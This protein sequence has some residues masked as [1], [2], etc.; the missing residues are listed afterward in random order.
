MT[1]F[2]AR[3]TLVAPTRPRACA[4]VAISAE[5]AFVLERAL[6]WADASRG[7]FDPA[8]ARVVDLWDVKHKHTPPPAP[9]LQRLAGRRLY[10][11]IDIA[12]DWEQPTVFVREPDAA[13]DLGGIAAGYGVD[14]AVQV[15]R[16]WG[17]TDGYVNV[18]GDI[19]ALG[20]SPAGEPWEVGVRSPSDPGALIG[21]VALSDGA[22]ATSG[23][24]EQGYTLNGRRYHHIIDPATAEPR[25]TPMH[26]LTVTASCCLVADAAST[27]VYGWNAAEANRL[28]S[29]MAPGAQLTTA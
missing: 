6:A 24:Y 21:N 15:L 20:E 11:R 26:S 3:S 10:R 28:L 19:Y 29:V 18:G 1:R 5:T 16:E 9:A 8:L 23:D 14:R 17:I 13:I 25:L 22:I 12:N 4:R 2:D 27:A 7:A